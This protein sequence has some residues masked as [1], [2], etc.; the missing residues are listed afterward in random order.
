M[1]TGHLARMRERR[2]SFKT[3]NDKVTCRRPKERPKN[4]PED[5][6]DFFSEKDIFN[7]RSCVR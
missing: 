1:W 2:S 5:D 6:I 3:L 7:L 4:R